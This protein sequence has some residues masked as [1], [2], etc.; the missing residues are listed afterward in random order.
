MD[1]NLRRSKRKIDYLP[2]VVNA[3]DSDNGK[4]I[5]GPFSGRII[6]ISDHGACLLMTQV[7]R[8]S[9]H[10]FHSTREK[11]PYQLQLAITIPPEIVTPIIINAF[12]IWLSIY[13]KTGISAFKMGI[14]FMISPKDQQLKKLQQAILHH[15]KNRARWWAQNSKNDNNF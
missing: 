7:M 8:N 15:Q 14:E 13:R 6:D 12:P 3:I 2:I 5:A 10:I 4:I 11:N 1:T 9:Y